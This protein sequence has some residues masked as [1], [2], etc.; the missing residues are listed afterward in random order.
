MIKVDVL[1]LYAIRNLSIKLFKLALIDKN[2][3][4]MDFITKQETKL[5]AECINVEE[6]LK[7][8][9]IKVQIFKGKL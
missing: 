4:L 6:S 7:Q 8:N 9:K 2:F 5:V 1:R 3:R